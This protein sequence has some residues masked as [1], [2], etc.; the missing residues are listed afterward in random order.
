MSRRL[1][2]SDCGRGAACSCACALPSSTCLKI[3][4]AR[5]AETKA[6]LWSS[7]MQSIAGC[8]RIREKWRALLM[9][10]LSACDRISADDQP[11]PKAIAKHEQTGLFA[12]SKQPSG[13]IGLSDDRRTVRP[14][15]VASSAL[16]DFSK[17]KKSAHIAT[18]LVLVFPRLLSDPPYTPTPT[19]IVRHWPPL[20]LTAL[21]A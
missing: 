18:G 11:R 21:G 4:R 9:S 5:T 13:A 19:I 15:N 7:R 3:P 8:R 1:C 2:V 6:L 17:K 20:R 12:R 10:S 14:C 16:R